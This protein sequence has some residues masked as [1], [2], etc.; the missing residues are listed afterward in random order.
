MFPPIFFQTMCTSMSLLPLVWRMGQIHSIFCKHLLRYD[1]IEW[2]SPLLVGHGF[3]RASP[4]SHGR[5]LVLFYSKD[6]CLLWEWHSHRFRHNW[7]KTAIMI[8]HALTCVGYV[9]DGEWVFPRC[10]HLQHC[11]VCESQ[12]HI[13]QRSAR[14]SY[15]NARH[16]Q[17]S[18]PQA[19]QYRSRSHVQQEWSH[20]CPS[21]KCRWDNM[22]SEWWFA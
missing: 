3:K 2:C 19:I 22:C 10:R 21:R 15:S 9:W 12:R 1:G 11:R 20:W 6:L 8:E 17:H 16:N 13:A 18:I 4:Y 7:D 14:L 5:H